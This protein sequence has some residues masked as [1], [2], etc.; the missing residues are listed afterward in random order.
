MDQRSGEHLGDRLT[1]LWRGRR[2]FNHRTSI[3]GTII[4]GPVDSKGTDGLTCEGGDRLTMG[5]PW[6]GL[7]YMDQ[8][9]R[10]QLEDRWT[11]L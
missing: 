2:L 4:H 5:L 3:A 11:D 8:Q 6:Q 1:D 9:T 7:L 10:E